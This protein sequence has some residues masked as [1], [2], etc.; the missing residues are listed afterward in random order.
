MK[1]RT[2]AVVIS[3]G[4][5]SRLWPRSRAALPKQFQDLLGLGRTM[6][7][8][9]CDRVAGLVTQTVIIT[10]SSQAKLAQSQIPEAQVVLEPCA[11]NT[12]AAIGLAAIHLLQKDP[13]AIMMVLPCDHHITNEPLLQATLG[14]AVELADRGRLVTIGLQPTFAHP[15]LGYILKG[16]PLND[17]GKAFCVE[18][19]H[20]KPGQ[21][22]AEEYVASG[23]WLWNSGMFVWRADAYLRAVEAH[24]PDLS[25]GLGRIAERIGKS[26]CGVVMRAVFPALP[27]ISV[28]HGVLNHC[29]HLQAVLEAAQLGWSDIGSWDVFGSL[30][31]PDGN[32]NAL[33][34]GVILPCVTGVEESAG[35]IV[36]SREGHTVVLLGVRDLVVA[37]SDGVTLVASKSLCHRVGDAMKAVLEQRRD[38]A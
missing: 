31:P 36:Y 14:S 2:Y 12:A 7:Q 8:K 35:N 30:V 28:D 16:A 6:I 37:V 9:T 15:L 13:E 32:G 1:K 4:I 26:D 33:A 17:H 19:F 23:S 38:L 29:P 11:R 20:E 10:N 34:G 25:R 5:G 24:L 22:T 3:G 18:R 27:N 21:Q